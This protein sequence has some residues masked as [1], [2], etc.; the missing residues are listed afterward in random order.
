MKNYETAHFVVFK[1]KEG[2][3]SPDHDDKFSDL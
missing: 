2:E 1:G 3:P